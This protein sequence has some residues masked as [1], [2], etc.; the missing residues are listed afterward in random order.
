MWAE[1]TC[2]L[3]QEGSCRREAERTPENYA[4]ILI[5]LH[6]C[7]LSQHLLQPAP[8]LHSRQWGSTRL[9]STQV[10]FSFRKLA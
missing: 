6:T 10:P 5:A 7:H 4:S 3:V 1:L 8:H 9:H 2:R